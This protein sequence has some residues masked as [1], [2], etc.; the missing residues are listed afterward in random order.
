MNRHNMSLADSTMIYFGLAISNKNASKSIAD[1]YDIITFTHF[2][3]SLLLIHDLVLDN[4]T[5]VS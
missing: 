2:N 5:R 4:K 3:Y 1:L